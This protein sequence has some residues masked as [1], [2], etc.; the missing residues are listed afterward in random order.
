[1]LLVSRCSFSCFPVCIF[2]V[3][4]ISISCHILIMS[5][6]SHFKGAQSSCQ[7]KLVKRRVELKKI[8]KWCLI[9]R[10][11]LQII[12]LGEVRGT[13]F[14]GELNVE[15]KFSQIRGLDT[16]AENCNV[17][18]FGLLPAK[19]STKLKNTSF[20]THF[21]HFKGK[22]ELLWKIHLYRLLHFFDHRFLLLCKNS[23]KTKEM[24]LRKTSYIHIDGLI[25]RFKFIEFYNIKFVISI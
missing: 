19:T 18:H 22:Q 9:L 23:E 15:L 14:W 4:K 2:G 16:K 25:L 13:E 24:I 11:D 12:F 1:M 7:W 6:M 17:V 5:P 10:G 21:L 20:W 8:S 3:C